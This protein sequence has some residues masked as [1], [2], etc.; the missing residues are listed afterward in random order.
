MT[1]FTEK[2]MLATLSIRRWKASKM[3]REIS[4]GVAEQYQMD[5]SFGSYSKKLLPKHALVEVT[6]AARAARDF[7][8]TETLPWAEDKARILPA[9][10]YMRYAGEMS[11]LKGAFE[12]AATDFVSQYPTYRGEARASL[13]S[14]YRDADYPTPEQIVD[15]FAF[16]VEISP[17]PSARDFRVSLA[18]EEAAAIRAQIEARTQAAVTEAARDLWLRAEEAV[19]RLRDRAKALDGEDVAV[20]K[21]AV[22]ETV[23]AVA[24]MLDRLNM[25]DDPALD[26]MRRQIET[27]LLAFPVEDIRLNPEVRAH[28]RSNADS[29]LAA[30]AGYTGGNH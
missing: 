21:G 14:A 28:V 4:E 30:M 20:L 13:G 26:A 8:A 5:R 22:L 29:I 17:L 24:G 19:T 16:T 15:A 11:R 23:R 3:D 27:E 10:N 18:D 7:H 1:D 2:A 25:T 9:K 6:R 12:A